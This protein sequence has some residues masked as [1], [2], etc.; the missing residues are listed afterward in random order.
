LGKVLRIT[1]IGVD[2]GKRAVERVHVVA[3]PASQTMATGHQRMTNDAV[4]DLDAFD[5][6][7]NGFHPA[8][9]FVPHDVGKPDVDLAPPDALDDVQIGT[10]DAGATDAHDDVRR[11]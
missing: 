3:A 1:T 11:A 9:I 4:T 8:G 10:T 2:S 6:G 7:P 5:A